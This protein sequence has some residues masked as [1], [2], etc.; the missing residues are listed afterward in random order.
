MLACGGHLSGRF[1]KAYNLG[2]AVFG[3]ILSLSR[4]LIGRAC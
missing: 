1:G 2:V 3:Q 4:L